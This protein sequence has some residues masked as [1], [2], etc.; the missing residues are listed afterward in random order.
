M[1]IFLKKPSN[2]SLNPSVRFEESNS[3]LSGNCCR[4]RFDLSIGPE[5]N[6]GKNMI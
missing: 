5:I 4:N 3:F 6:F 2:A 1:I